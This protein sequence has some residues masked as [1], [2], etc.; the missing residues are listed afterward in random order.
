MCLHDL[1]DTVD[2]PGGHILLLLG[3]FVLMIAL[4]ACQ[5]TIP[6]IEDFLVG[7]FGAL[8]GKL[9]GLRSNRERMNGSAP[10]PP[11]HPSHPPSPIQA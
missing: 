10:K 9:S 3:I 11:G 1:I 4:S 2:S 7:T 8:L 6:K 5:F